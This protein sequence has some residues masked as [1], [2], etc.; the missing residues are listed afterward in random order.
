MITSPWEVV[1]TFDHVLSYRLLPSI[2]QTFSSKFSQCRKITV[3]WKKNRDWELR[4]PEKE[5]TNQTGLVVLMFS[6]GNGMLGGMLWLPL[7]LIY[8]PCQI[9]SNLMWDPL[10]QR[11]ENSKAVD[12]SF[13]NWSNIQFLM[14]YRIQIHHIFLLQ[15][16]TV[17]KLFTYK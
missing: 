14:P 5:I 13:G 10:S 4:S 15:K 7:F 9:N 12:T 8:S 3:L 16:Y 11:T 17:E 6:E 2:L 1:F